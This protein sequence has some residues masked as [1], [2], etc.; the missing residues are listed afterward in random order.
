[1]ALSIGEGYSILFNG[2][3]LCTGEVVV[4]NAFF[5]VRVTGFSR[6]WKRRKCR[7]TSMIRLR[8]FRLWCSLRRLTRY[9]QILQTEELL[10]IG[11]G[12]I[13]IPDMEALR[14]KA[15]I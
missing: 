12:H 11:R 14:C 2:H 10:T 7:P 6:R 8:C 9:L 4:C 15:E 13:E 5:G 1:M 3:F